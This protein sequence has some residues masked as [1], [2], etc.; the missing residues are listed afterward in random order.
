[1]T[2]RRNHRKPLPGLV[3]AMAAIVAAGG[4]V[5]YGVTHGDVLERMAAPGE[6]G[7]SEGLQQVAGGQYAGNV[8]GVYLPAGVRP[9]AAVEKAVDVVLMDWMDK[10]RGW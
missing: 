3:E 8:I 4:K 7:R 6:R 9:G 5:R 10:E 1:M 2:P